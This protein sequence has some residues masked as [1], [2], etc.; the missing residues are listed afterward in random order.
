MSSFVF[1]CCE[2][3]KKL[4]NLHL[5]IQVISDPLDMIIITVN[6]NIYLNII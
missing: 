4:Y 5:V 3:Q 1:C 2:K 6:D